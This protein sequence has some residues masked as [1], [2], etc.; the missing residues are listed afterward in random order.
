MHF[1][2]KTCS[3]CSFP[4]VRIAD[5][6][7]ITHDELLCTDTNSNDN[8][9]ADA[10]PSFLHVQIK[11]EEPCHTEIICGN[12][13][14]DG[15]TLDDLASIEKWQSSTPNNEKPV[16]NN[17][18]YRLKLHTKLNS[19]RCNICK[20][21]FADRRS[22]AR[23]VK[24]FHEE[25]VTEYVQPSLRRT[26]CKICGK[27]LNNKY[28]L[29]RHVKFIHKDASTIDKICESNEDEQPMQ[30]ENNQIEAFV[31]ASFTEESVEHSGRDQNQQD[32]LDNCSDDAY[33]KPSLKRVRCKICRRILNNKYSFQRH[34]KQI[35]KDASNIDEICESIEDDQPTQESVELTEDDENRKNELSNRFDDSHKRPSL[36]RIGCEMCERIFSNVYSLRRHMKI[37]H[38]DI[39]NIEQIHGRH[40][41][42]KDEHQRQID[43]TESNE[44]DTSAENADWQK[45]PS[46][47]RIRCQMCDKILTNMYSLR[48][49]MKH[50]HKITPNNDD[51]CEQ[52]GSIE[53]EHSMD[54]E[55]EQTD[56][57]SMMRS[58]TE[59]V[60][61]RVKLKERQT[62][63]TAANS[64][65]PSEHLPKNIQ[66][67]L[68][69]SKFANVGNLGQ[70]MKHIHKN[71]AKE[72]VIRV[73]SVRPKVI[74][75]Q[76]ESP[77]NECNICG[78]SFSSFGNMNA[79]MYIHAETKRYI[80]NFCGRGFNMSNSLRQHLNMHEGKYPYKCK[81]CA[82]GFARQSEL[83][84]HTRT[85]TGEKPFKCPI[86]QCERAYT[87][88]IDLKRH[89]FSAHGIY[90]KKYPCSIC[91]KIYSENKLLRKHMESHTN[92]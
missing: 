39:R 33:K 3:V 60:K 77:K 12:N 9:V 51:P 44:N 72:T 36:R 59:A 48:R 47:R 5:D 83:I 22:F 82:K 62:R 49:H 14:E 56:K 84:A 38:K 18:K 34:V 81:F 53:D 43:Q 55:R 68:C 11:S 16:A 6:W 32:E 61:Y 88:Q 64:L 13:E 86:D 74:A 50:V 57:S 66:C 8:P 52:S 42:I 73:R 75:N 58:T 69:D 80:C 87:Y 45:S 31:G 41:S 71:P 2:T 7:Y 79:H 78:R 70:H 17:T 67:Q 37:I 20:K 54:V 27:L 4:L 25:H 28:S 29:R 23:H 35:H 92:I 46:H 26:R 10:E 19:L 76:N 89:K 63:R 90:H 21:I 85:H 30:I 24:R 91:N 40:V 65:I 15:L 1:L